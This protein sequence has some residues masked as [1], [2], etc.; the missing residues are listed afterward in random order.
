MYRM[1]R[2]FSNTKLIVLVSVVVVAS[3]I[4]VLVLKDGVKAE[5][6]LDDGSKKAAIIDQLDADIPNKYFQDEAVN[7]LEA[8]GYKVD[9][10]TTKDITVDFYK[11]L[12][13]MNY[14]FIVIRTHGVAD[15]SEEKSVMLFTG[16]RYTE[17]K[18]ITEQI[19]GQVKRGT[20]LL[21]VQ[22][23]ANTD[24]SSEWQIVNDTY[25]V[26]KSPVK[27]EDYAKDK[28]FGITPQLVDELM[29]GK[30]P[31][32]TFLLGGCNTM[33]NPS[34]AQALIKRGALNVLG[35]SNPVG[36]GD[37][38]TVMLLLLKEILI[39]DAKIDD[40]VNQVAFMPFWSYQKYNS[41]LKYYSE[42]NA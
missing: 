21:E 37:N 11:R 7:Y 24:D 28:Y 35:W 5:N 20:P 33:T 30:F 34:M 3:F 40:V 14:K 17:D 41:T 42:T 32:T 8:A 31:G 26:L 16:E 18:Y 27:R 2:I 38:D 23:G 22:F 1:K 10:Y 25:R 19:F 29:I 39:N 15:Q 9:L 4:S 6:L 36:S 13:E 12:P